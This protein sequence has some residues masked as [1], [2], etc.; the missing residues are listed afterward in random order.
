MKIQNMRYLRGLAVLVSAASLVVVSPLVRADEKKGHG[1]KEGP[2]SKPATSA[3]AL[4]KA[5]T[6]HLEI[7]GQVKAKNLKPVHDA[8]ERMT[9]TLKML[10]GLSKHLAAD[11][12]K[13]VDGTVQNLAKALDALHDAADEGKQAES[14]QRLA[15]VD[16]LLKMLDAQYPAMG[17][18]KEKAGHAH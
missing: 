17:T 3:A 11:K 15:T 16:S 4:E 2:G 9:E 5:H 12:Q 10:P 13:R 14:E 7:A 18:T 8:A 1:H 6:L